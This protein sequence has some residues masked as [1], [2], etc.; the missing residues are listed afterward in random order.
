VLKF[1]PAWLQINYFYAF[2]HI[3]ECKKA[4][5][6]RL[7]CPYQR[8]LSTHLSSYY[9][10]FIF[11]SLTAV[12]NANNVKRMPANKKL[13]YKNRE[14]PPNVKISFYFPKNICSIAINAPIWPT[15]NMNIHFIMSERIFSIFISNL[16]LLF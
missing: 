5:L 16:W 12:I 15:Q 3:V 11:S 7:Q 4:Q 14:C 8:V 2:S 6:V 9:S 10:S 1:L 13:C